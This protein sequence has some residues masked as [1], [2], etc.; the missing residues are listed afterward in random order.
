MIRLFIIFLF[1]SFASS[2]KED[3]VSFEEKYISLQWVDVVGKDYFKNK[4]E[5]FK[6]NRYSVTEK[7]VVFWY[8]NQDMASSF[9]L[10]LVPQFDSSVFLGLDSYADFFWSLGNTEIK[11]KSFSKWSLL[12]INEKGVGFVTVVFA[13][14]AEDG[15]VIA[16]AVGKGKV[17]LSEVVRGKPPRKAEGVSP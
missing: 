5:G 4:I 7:G 6:I 14:F 16:S 15:S 3:F 8:L 13:T 9:P 2:A 10:R 1:S 17:S 11:Y 12:A